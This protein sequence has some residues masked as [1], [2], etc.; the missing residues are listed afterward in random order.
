METKAQADTSSSH[1]NSNTKLSEFGDLH[2]S[3]SSLF[4]KHKW[5]IKTKE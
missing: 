2:N 3:Q 5:E 1:L 4:I